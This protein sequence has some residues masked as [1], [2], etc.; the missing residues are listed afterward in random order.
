MST[1]LAPAAL[2]LAALFVVACG[3][4]AVS[5]PSPSAP[6]PS[7][8][9]V[10]SPTSSPTD[11]NLGDVDGAQ[12]GRPELVVESAGTDRIR[13]TITDPEAK[14]WRLVVASRDGQDRM[15][16]YVETGDIVPGIRV[17]EVIGGDTVGSDDLTRMPEDETVAAGGC[18]PTVMVCWA[19]FDITTPGPEGTLAVFLGLPEPAAGFSITG[20][21]ADWPG[22]PF[23]LGEWRDSLTFATW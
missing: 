20:S 21:T 11:P 2:V 19:S 16:L 5:S 22:E 13:I 14:A 23:I 17:D 4:S 10:P 9:T 3:P 7:S 15:E 12:D 8:P 6:A 18:H 1:R